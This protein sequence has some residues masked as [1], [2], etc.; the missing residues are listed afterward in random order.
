MSLTKINYGNKKQPRQ[1]Y[2]VSHRMWLDRSMVQSRV[3]EFRKMP[4]VPSTTC[5]F[6]SSSNLI[7]FKTNFKQKKKRLFLAPKWSRWKRLSFVLSF[8]R[9]F[10][11]GFELNK[12][13]WNQMKLD[14]EFN[15]I[16]LNVRFNFI[17]N[18]KKLDYIYFL[19][20][21]YLIKFDLIFY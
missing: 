16:E 3:R 8:L 19:I 10:E 18:V 13:W 2:T 17:F 21:Y 9:L 14:V 11:V 5:Q 12:I 6:L 4:N 15:K 1:Y 20:K 7:Q